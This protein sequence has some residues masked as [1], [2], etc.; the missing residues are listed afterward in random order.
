MG[1]CNINFKLEIDITYTHFDPSKIQTF[2]FSYLYFSTHT[3]YRNEQD[4]NSTLLDDIRLYTF[5]RDDQ[6]KIEKKKFFEHD[7]LDL[8]DRQKKH[9]IT[10]EVT[11]ELIIKEYQIILLQ[12]LK[13]ILLFKLY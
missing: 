4:L 13:T 7:Q 5:R 8:I 9:Y 1:V 6:P 2:Y 11:D 12:V 10:G 3:V